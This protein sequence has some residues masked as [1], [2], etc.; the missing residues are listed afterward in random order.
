MRSRRSASCSTAAGHSLTPGVLR[1]TMTSRRRTRWQDSPRSPPQASSLRGTGVRRIGPRADERGPP[2]IPPRLAMPAAARSPPHPQGLAGPSPRSRHPAA[3][4]VGP[5]LLSTARRPRSPTGRSSLRDWLA[6]HPAARTSAT[7]DT[8]KN[9]WS[10]DFIRREG[11]RAGRGLRRRRDRRI[12]ETRTGPQVA[13]QM[14][15]G[16]EGAFGRAVNEP[17]IWIPLLVAFL[18]PLLRWRRIVSWHTLDL[19]RCS[20]PSRLAGRGSTGGDLH[21]GAPRLPAHGLPRGRACLDRD[22][23]AGPRPPTTDEARTPRRSPTS[24]PAPPRAGL[25]LVPHVALCALMLFAL[26]LRYRLERVR[27]ER[28]RRRLRRRDRRR[29]DRPRGDPVRDFPGDCGQCDTYGPVTYLT[30]VPFEAVFPWIGKWNDLPAAHGAAVLFDLAA[31]GGM[32]VLGWRHRRAAAG[33]RPRPR[34]GG[35]PVHRVCAG[36]QLERLAD[37][38]RLIWGLAFAAPAAGACSAGARGSA[39]SR[40]RSSSAL[41]AAIRSRAPRGRRRAC[42]PS[43]RG[44]AA[45]PRSPPAG[46]SCS[47]GSTACARSGRARSAYQIDRDSPFSLW[48]QYPGLRPVQIGLTC[49]CWPPRSPSPAGRGGSISWL[50]RRCR[51]R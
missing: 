47:T 49:S 5:G 50:S 31:L 14:A 23:P 2:P 36:E 37:G 27:C 18:I 34:V 32:L 42:R 10:V 13:W 38:G 19:W 33:G 35:V 51:A 39:S 7:R 3:D 11:A 12:T 30:Y 44:L 28:D 25:R 1:L 43:S 40:P 29:P 6:D 46:S 26:G 17:Q 16:Y 41:V 8:E 4:H 15:R 45:C 20:R 48:G 24:G 21:V 9:L 22:P